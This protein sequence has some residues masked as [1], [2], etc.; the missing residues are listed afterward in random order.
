[1]SISTFFHSLNLDILYFLCIHCHPTDVL[2]LITARSV[3]VEGHAFTTATT[4]TA[5]ATTWMIHSLYSFC[6]KILMTWVGNHFFQGNKIRTYHFCIAFFYV[7]A[8][9][10]NIV[11]NEQMNSVCGILYKQKFQFYA[12]WFFFMYEKKRKDIL[13]IG[14][15]AFMV[16]IWC[17]WL[18]FFAIHCLHYT[19]TI[20][21]ILVLGRVKIIF[22][23]WW[24]TLLD[25]TF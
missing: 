1:M 9:W 6:D 14:F 5:A 25:V 16:T 7:S 11:D 2:Y 24:K 19:F 3:I 8:T 12:S 4:N 10:A 20:H 18:D 13:M 23:T 22:E 15:Y 21:A 17:P